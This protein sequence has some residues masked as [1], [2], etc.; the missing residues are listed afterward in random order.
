V[1]QAGA[2]CR[3]RHS[4][5]ASRWSD[6]LDRPL[7]EIGADR[8]GVRERHRRLTDRHGRATADYSMRVLRAVYNRGMRE[9][10]ELTPNPCANVDLHGIRRR[11][12][13]AGADRLREW[14]E[15]VLTLSP[16]KRDLQLFMLLTGMRRT[17]A[18]EAR[19][20]HFDEQ[21]GCLRVPNPKGGESRAFDLPL[22]GALLDLMRLRIEENRVIDA[23]SPWLFPSGSASGHVAEAR[24][25]A[26][27]ELVGHALR[28]V[29]ATLAL[30][31]GVPIAE[32][33]F[34]LNHAV[35]SGGV[36]MGYLHPSLDHLRGWQEKATARILAAI[37]L[38][39][40]ALSQSPA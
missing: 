36:T 25:D 3:R 30:E 32:L 20:E 26:L 40:D 10:P 29:Y 38:G 37:G 19:I 39:W 22:S 14:G 23:D 33:K 31:A 12:V 18:V 35:S 34:L 28:H 16:V 21:R 8:A 9:H 2:S 6:W 4:A 13:E 11:R 7:C 1:S 5:I 24:V 15:A 27:G 17:A